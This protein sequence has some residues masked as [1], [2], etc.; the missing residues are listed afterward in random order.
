MFL[1]VV[2]GMLWFWPGTSSHMAQQVFLWDLEMHQRVIDL[3]T[4]QFD[5]FLVAASW[6]INLVPATFITLLLSLA[7]AIGLRTWQTGLY[8]SLSVLLAYLVTHWLKILL[9]RQRPPVQVHLIL[10]QQF[11]YP[12]GH[13]T[14]ITAL[15]AGLMIVGYWAR[16]RRWAKIL[17]L[18]IFI[19]W[20]ALICFSRLY[21]GVHWPTDVIAGIMVGLG[22]PL[23]TSIYLELVPRPV[24]RRYT[25]PQTPF[26]A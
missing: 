14:T 19:P 6:P 4:P 7:V 2:A 18:A 25:R 23:L 5:N 13:A 12:S 20:S 15:C 3:R 21:L 11:S 17:M 24:K 26:G 9:G 22:V 8:L 10:E 1:V 16:Y